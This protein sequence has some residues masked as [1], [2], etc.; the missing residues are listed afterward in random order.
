MGAAK[1]KAKGKARTATHKGKRKAAARRRVVID[2][3]DEDDDDDDDDEAAADLEEAE[4]DG[5]EPEGEGEGE[6]DEEMNE[7][8]GQQAKDVFLVKR[9]LT[10]EERADG[11]W[12]FVDWLHWSL[13]EATWE[14]LANILTA[15]AEV[16]EFEE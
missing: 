2:S 7:A 10:K 9:I 11:T 6:E 14:P 15:N 16:R 12:Y 1:K 3:S 4:E 5:E 13:D 8:T